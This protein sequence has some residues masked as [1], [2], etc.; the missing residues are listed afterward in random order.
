M[1]KILRLSCHTHS[2]YL[3]DVE[4]VLPEYSSDS[5]I[6]VGFDRSVESKRTFQIWDADSFIHYYARMRPHTRFYHEY[7]QPSKPCRVFFDI[8]MK[9]ATI[10]ES[11]WNGYMYDID[12]AVRAVLARDL[13]VKGQPERITWN[14]HREG[15]FS[16]HV[17]YDLW[18][19]SVAVMKSIVHA[20]KNELPAETYKLVDKAVYSIG[21]HKCLRM[22]YSNKYEEVDQTSPKYPL[23]PE[24]GNPAFDEVAFR[25]SLIGYGLKPT[26][27]VYGADY[28]PSTP[29][30]VACVLSPQVLAHC[31][32][33]E[34]WL[35]DYEKVTTMVREE[36]S[37]T[38]VVWLLHRVYCPAKGDFHKSNGTYLTARF[39]VAG[40]PLSLEFRCTDPECLFAWKP[41]VSFRVLCYPDRHI[42]L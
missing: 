18:V 19:C 4:K 8:E 1:A 12:V 22:P 11:K 9:K 6:F 32:A 14:A 31:A 25:K 27:L 40:N 39:C 23:L 16:S 15:T 17:H 38:K 28:I 5:N 30:T 2:D 29:E 10:T 3:C 24:D 13:G 42:T 26:D 7:I 34:K 33:V 37:P 35:T 36:R 20:M 41:A 21:A